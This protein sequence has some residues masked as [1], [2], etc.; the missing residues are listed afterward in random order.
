MCFF[1]LV[2]AFKTKRR[3]LILVSMA[4]LD[5][6]ILPAFC[7]TQSMESFS[8]WMFLLQSSFC[9]TFTFMSHKP[10][11]CLL[12]RYS[13]YGHKGNTSYFLSNY[14]FFLTYFI[15][16]PS[17][18]LLAHATSGDSDLEEPCSKMRAMSVVC[19]QYF[20]MLQSTCDEKIHFHDCRRWHVMI[21]S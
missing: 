8:C 9:V 16:S 12:L 10:E 18:P 13:L 2:P 14:S 15:V 1:A 7:L 4:T 20:L 3:S 17:Y 11:I 5:K 6:A 19:V 21:S